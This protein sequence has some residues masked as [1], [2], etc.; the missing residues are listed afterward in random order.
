MNGQTIV[1]MKIVWPGGYADP[2]DP[3]ETDPGYPAIQKTTI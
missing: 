1:P 3:S 2:V